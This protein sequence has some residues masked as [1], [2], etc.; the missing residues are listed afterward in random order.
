MHD[1]LHDHGADRVSEPNPESRVADC[2]DA[3]PDPALRDPALRGKRPSADCDR[4]TNDFSPQAR[5]TT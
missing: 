1:P 4:F 3:R 2:Y 5:L